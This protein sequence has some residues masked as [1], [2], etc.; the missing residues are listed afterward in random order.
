MQSLPQEK[1]C[2]VAAVTLLGGNNTTT[3]KNNK[4]ETLQPAPEEEYAAVVPK[5]EYK[6]VDHSN[7]RNDLPVVCAYC[8]PWLQKCEKCKEPFTVSKKRVPDTTLCQGCYNGESAQK[9]DIPPS[10]WYCTRGK[11]H[12]G[13]CAF[14]MGQ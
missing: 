14:G 4:L 12:E 2:S 8:Y 1:S 6:H 7:C 3:I 9:C 13:P 11:G 10:G 5:E